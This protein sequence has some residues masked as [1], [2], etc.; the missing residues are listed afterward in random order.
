MASHP[1]GP[2]L[3]NTNGLPWSPPA[4]NC[5]LARLL[6]ALGR[7]KLEDLGLKPPKLR[8]LSKARRSD[9]AVSRAH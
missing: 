4:L 6:L 5:R 2:L 1:H 8:R 9:P 7:K 3:L